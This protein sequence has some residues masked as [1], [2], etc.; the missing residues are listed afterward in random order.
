MGAYSCGTVRQFGDPAATPDTVES[1]S[2]VVSL[3]HWTPSLPAVT[4][5]GPAFGSGG[6]FRF[7]IGTSGP[8][9]IEGFHGV[10]FG[11]RSGRT[12]GVVDVCRK[13]C[14]RGGVLVRRPLRFIAERLAAF[15]E[16]GV[17]TLS[18]SPAAAEPGKPVHQVEEL[19]EQRPA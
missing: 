9:V 13:V 10:E 8:Q 5:A 3:H 11:A 4:A 16:S 1:A 18:V 7:G 14:R 12:R 17:T 6:R 19:L 15:T 2:G